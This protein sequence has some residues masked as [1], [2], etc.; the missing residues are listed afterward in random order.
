MERT[1]SDTR[2]FYTCLPNVAYS[3]FSPRHPKIIYFLLGPRPTT[4][5]PKCCFLL[6]PALEARADT[7][8]TYADI[9][10]GTKLIWGKK[11]TITISL[12]VISAY[13]TEEGIPQWAVLTGVLRVRTPGSVHRMPG[14]GASTTCSGGR[15]RES[16]AAPWCPTLLLTPDCTAGIWLAMREGICQCPLAGD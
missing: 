13:L 1:P 4:A 14:V 15:C 10:S 6:M 16:H 3:F 12:R 7:L 9:K 2:D 11:T 5:P 8:I